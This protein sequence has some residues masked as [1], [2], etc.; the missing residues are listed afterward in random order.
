[1]RPE[2]E[3]SISGQGMKAKGRECDWPAHD[4]S[5]GQEGGSL[6]RA[7]GISKCLMVLM[8]SPE[9]NASILMT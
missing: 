6:E 9:S 3:E 8:H 5:M 7:D 4:R 1:M 2:V